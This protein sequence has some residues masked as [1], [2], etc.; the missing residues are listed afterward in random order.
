[1][2]YRCYSPCQPCSRYTHTHTHTL[3]S[4]LCPL[5]RML[6]VV[7]VPPAPHWYV[8]HVCAH[9]P[10]QGRDAPD[11][12]MQAAA[13]L[14]SPTFDPDSL[15]KIYFKAIRA[16]HPDKTVD[17]PEEVKFEFARIFTVLTEAYRRHQEG[18]GK[19]SAGAP[20]RGTGTAA[21]RPDP[22]AKPGYRRSSFTASAP[23][24]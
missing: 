14:S 6:T 7:C 19:G 12:I 23:R 16:V 4:L 9:A 10:L 13:G 17:A 24:R 8:W 1:M 15:K 2:W 18:G 11:G 5:V 20:Q 3:N 22:G 21:A